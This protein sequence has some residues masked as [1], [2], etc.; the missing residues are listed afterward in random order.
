[1]EK[2]GSVRSP[3]HFQQTPVS[4][5]CMRKRCVKHSFD[6]LRNNNLIALLWTWKW[7]A[8]PQ[9]CD[10]STPTSLLKALHVAALPLHT[11][12]SS[13]ASCHVQAAQPQ[14]YGFRGWQ[15]MVASLQRWSGYKAKECKGKGE[16]KTHGER[17]ESEWQRERKRDLF[18][19]RRAYTQGQTILRNAKMAKRMWPNTW[20]QLH[21]ANP[22]ISALTLFLTH[23]TLCKCVLR[24][25]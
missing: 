3:Q 25:Q 19:N 9:Q 8:P 16:V 5:H 15:H 17:K 21:D 20:V 7:A 11:Q 13:S 14:H 24:W 1:M 18:S 4:S 22:H 6:L 10:N 2:V 12:H 23:S